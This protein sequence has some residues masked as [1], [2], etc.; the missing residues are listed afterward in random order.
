MATKEGLELA[1][2]AR[3]FVYL[4]KLILLKVVGKINRKTVAGCCLM[5]AAKATDAKS[6]EYAKLLASLSSELGVPVQRFLDTEFLVLAK[7]KFR[8]QVDERQFGCHLRRI[9]N[10]LDYSNLQEYLG[11][12]MYQTWESTVDLML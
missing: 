7:L 5:L 4:E 6:I 3:S 10:A 9:L 11:E 8:L 12:R 1:T 2:L